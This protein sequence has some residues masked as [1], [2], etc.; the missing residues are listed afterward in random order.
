MACVPG[1]PFWRGA[2]DGEPDERPR[3]RATVST[4]YIDLHEV[5]N[6]EFQRCVTAGACRRPMPY[7]EFT[8]PRQ[9][10]VATDWF[11]ARDYCAWLGKRLPTEA[12]WEKAARGTDGA[13]YPWG[14]ERPSCERAQYDGCKPATTLPVGGFAAGF[15]GLFDMAGNSW[16]W[17]ADWH[18]DCYAG[19]DDACGADCEGLDPRGPCGGADVCPGRRFRVLKGGSW[20]WPAERLRASERRAMHPDSGVHRLGFR[21]AIG[22]DEPARRVPVVPEVPDAHPAGRVD[23]GAPE[24]AVAPLG[25]GQHEL[26]ATAPEEV[27]ERPLADPRHYVRSNERRLDAWFPYIDG[28][29][30]GYFGIGADQNYT[31]LARARS[32]F[33]WLMD[34]DAVVVEV[35]RV[36]RALVLASADPEG[37]VACWD[38]ER[39]EQTLALLA[40]AYPGDPELPAL[41]EIY[42]RT[43]PLLTVY[44]HECLGRRRMRYPTGWLSDPA[45]Y[46]YVRRMMVEG[47]IRFLRGD[48][49]GPTTVRGIGDAARRLGV[50][51]RVV[52]L[53]NAEEWFRYDDA[54][55]GSIAALPGDGTSVVLRTSERFELA[56]ADGKWNYQVQSLADFVARLGDPGVAGLADFVRAAKVDEQEGSSRLGVSVPE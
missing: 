38:A 54:F 15:W 23:G 48:L 22:A 19:C 42:R 46:R 47:R 27:L 41:E 40:A 35:H 10:I 39:E 50:P 21:C 37:F 13:V 53:S 25:P 28:L 4:F 30:G 17:V 2:D 45:L 49:L 18:S 1:G 36:Y 12:E 7:R 34:Y 33:A 56:P 8:R 14:D 5:T 32:D 9:P 52:Y 26:L 43:Q 55:R 44:F 20:Y 29:G 51:I 16:E 6:E 11:N 3:H 31:L 24:T